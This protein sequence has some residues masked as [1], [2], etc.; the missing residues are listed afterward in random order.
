MDF[1]PAKQSIV[2]DFIGERVGHYPRDVSAPLR[3]FF[4]VW[5]LIDAAGNFQPKTIR[6]GGISLVVFRVILKRRAAPHEK[7]D[8][9]E[10]GNSQCMGHRFFQGSDSPNGAAAA[11]KL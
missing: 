8:R 2:L 5:P 1:H 10:Y 11:T 7:T 4:L 3:A 6:D 9:R